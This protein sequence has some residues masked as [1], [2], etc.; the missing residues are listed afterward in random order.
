MGNRLSTLAA[1]GGGSG[2]VDNDEPPPLLREEVDSVTGASS[3]SGHGFD[4][5]SNLSLMGG[6]GAAATKRASASASA[7]AAAA[8]AIAPG[9][10]PSGTGGA[11]AE[12]LARAHSATLPAAAAATAAGD[13]GAGGPDGGGGD[14]RA[15]PSA[16]E[17]PP[18][19]RLPAT[20]AAYGLGAEEL[21]L[22]RALRASGEG[23]HRSGGGSSAAGWG[24]A[25]G[26]GGEASGVAGAADVVSAAAVPPGAP[27]PAAPMLGPPLLTDDE[28]APEAHGEL[29]LSAGPG[30]G[31][32]GAA[33]PAPAPPLV[34]LG[35]VKMVE[36][37]EG[38]GVGAAGCALR[39]EWDIPLR[40]Q[41]GGG[42]AF[43]DASANEPCG[44][45]VRVASPPFTLA[46]AP[47]AHA[48]APPPSSAAAGAASRRLAA[49]RAAAP[50][51]PTWFPDESGASVAAD[52]LSPSW[53]L[54][55][56]LFDHDAS[57][58]SLYL[59]HTP[60]QHPQPAAAGTTQGEGEDPLQA[61]EAEGEVEGWWL[62]WRLE[63]AGLDGEGQVV[64]KLTVPGELSHLFRAGHRGWGVQALLSAPE[65]DG[66]LCCAML[67]VSATLLHPPTP[68]ADVLST[69][70][71]VA[72]RLGA[73][74]GSAATGGGAG[75]AASPSPSPDA[76]AR[77][78]AG[79]G[80]G[81]SRGGEGRGG[82]RL[83]CVPEEAGAQGSPHGLQPWGAVAAGGGG[84]G[85]GGGAGVGD[86]A[87]GEG[88]GAAG[89]PVGAVPRALAALDCDVTLASLSPRIVVVDGFLPPQLC[90]ALMATAEP[91]LIRSRV[92]TGA[93]TPSRVSRSTFFTG[94]S[95]R[96]GPVLAVE[97]RIQQLMERPE[98]TGGG[99]PTLVKSEALQVVCYQDGG[100]YAEHYDNKAGGVVTRAAT[101][102]IYLD[103]PRSGGGT[104]FP[105]STG[106]PRVGALAASPGCLGRLP[107]LTQ[108]LHTMRVARPGLRVLPAKGR[109]LIFW[110]RLADGSEDLASLHSAE[111][112]R[113]GTKWICTRWFKELA[114]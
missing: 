65:L 57:R 44:C 63:V 32:G 58:V 27:Q 100:F 22:T 95:A 113:G 35:G 82:G 37:G 8:A 78:G 107:A 51:A 89:F 33:P 49:A 38:Q 108:Q 91:R 46:A 79:A 5:L 18:P 84:G 6:G 7:A 43:L 11:L 77:A 104:Y 14:K 29:L 93:E 47:A 41:P 30:P 25:G 71:S 62:T 19:A 66:L 9:G 101:I 90:D 94:D 53:R 85:G 92:S 67:R 83:G 52:A 31:P 70:P 3:G 4:F 99:R 13:K 12:V 96:L 98:V 15:S 75:A 42:G 72:A 10:G 111:P 55:W 68:A 102:I 109:A 97:A 88:G 80:A 64:S 74:M 86:V 87:M 1:V 24:A 45:N 40:A 26:G 76:G 60:Q 23:G 36:A 69:W 81:S 16:F 17:L 2:S 59:L 106:L 50:A 28:A 105:K 110:S 61:A 54:C 48:P 21:N 103:E 112:V 56:A 39:A 73:Y 20:L 34:L 114:P